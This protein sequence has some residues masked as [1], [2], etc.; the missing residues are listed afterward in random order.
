M[1]I[2]R[3]NITSKHHY[4]SNHCALRTQRRPAPTHQREAQIEA[5]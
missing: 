2:T 4:S 3:D 1:E 5:V